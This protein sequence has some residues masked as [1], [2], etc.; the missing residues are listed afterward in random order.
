M[1]APPPTTG[2]TTPGAPGRRRAVV[3]LSGG[4]DSAT[5]LALARRDGF[6]C[7]ALS[8]HYGQRHSSELKAAAR[9]AAAL[10]AVEH[11]VFGVDLAGIGGVGQSRRHVG[12][13][14]DQFQAT[15]HQVTVLH[16]HLAGVHAA[17]PGS[18]P[19]TVVKRVKA[20]LS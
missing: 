18:D 17:L 2:T 11:R 7:H 12:G 1:S 9:V 6:D 20:G 3:L 13:Q 4:L 15:Q 10:G 16:E 19:A 14:A 5:V 8:V